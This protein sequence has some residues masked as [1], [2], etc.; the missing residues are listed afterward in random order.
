M[1]DLRIRQIQS[2]IPLLIEDLTDLFYLTGLTL[3]KG[4]LLVSSG[5]A[6]LYVDGR[7]Y[8]RAKLEAPCSVKLWEEFKNI[9]EKEMGFDSAFVTY[10][11]Y[12][13]M[14]RE[15][16]YITWTPKPHP[17]RVLRAIKEEEEI[18]RLERAAQLTWRGYKHVVSCLREGISEEEL[19]LEF[20]IFCRK[21][22]ASGL[23]FSPIIAFGENGAYPHYRAGKSR[24][25]KGQAVLIDVGAIVDHYCG[26]LTRMVYFGKPDS[27]IL[28]FEA[29]VKRAKEM[30]MESI[31]PGLQLGQ[32]DQIVQDEF[33]R[34]GVK[35]LYIHSLGHG[36]GLETHE[37]PR[38]RFD[39]PDRDVVLK[40][41]MVFTIEPG[42]YQPGVGGVR[43]EDMVVVTPMGYRNL[44]PDRE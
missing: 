30:A 39:S 4:R 33:E 9:Q 14:K 11:A 37:F 10:E 32:L 17:L 21:Q 34:L 28:Q 36:V 6:T 38:I 22:G 8:E 13:G 24:L 31:R 26:D 29:H 7:Y 5:K 40:A 35:Q 27:R 43:L 1:N 41:G 23:S 20:E 25:Q 3:S 44:F 18:A 16:P 19:A 15:F 42:L 2:E 12:Q